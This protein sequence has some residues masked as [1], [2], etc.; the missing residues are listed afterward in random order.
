ML[1]IATG[2]SPDY[3]LKE[4]ATGRENYYTGAVAEGE[5]PG[6]WWGAGAEQL[7]LAGLV[8]A[9]DMR[10]L[11]ERFLDPRDAGFG[12]PS[13]W[14]SVP[15]LGHTGRKYL[16]EDDLYAAALEREPDAAAER[17]AELRTE[18]GKAA[19]HNVAF[20]DATFSV[21]KSVTLLHTAFEARE[22]AARQAGDEATAAAWGEFRQAVEDAIW[23]GNNAALAYL[24]DKAGYA[25]V[26]HHGGAAG[27]WV[28][29]HAFTV[30]SFFQHDSRD[31]DPQLHI[32][33]AILNRI[34]GPDGV[35]RTLD[36]RAIHRWRAGAGAVGERTTEERLAATI[37]TLV[38]TRRDGKSREVVGVSAEAMSLVSNRR[39]AVTAKAAE[40][41]EAFE[42]RYG[43]APNGV[44][45]DRLAQQATLATRAAKSHDGETRGDMLDRVAARLQSDIAGGLAGIADTAL[46]ARRDGVTPQAF[47]PQ[48]VIEIALEDVASRK[49]GWTRSDLVRAV[50]AALPDYLGVPDGG[51]VAVLLD[52]ITDHALVYAIALE[53]E[54]PGSGLL[55]DELRVANGESAYIAPGGRVYCTPD[56]VRSERILLAAT[57]ARDGAALTGA[58]AERFLRTL[59]SEGLELGVD[60][61]AAVRGILTSGARVETLVGPAGTGKSYVVGN[62]ARAWT[63]PDLRPTGGPGG[64]AGRVFGLA[65]SQRATEVLTAEGLTAS[66]IARW[67]TTQDRLA[68][69]PAE[70][71][72]VDGDEA[73]RLREGDLLV[74]DESGMTD[75]AALAAIHQRADEAGAKLLLVGDHRQLAAVGAGGGMDLLATAGSRYELT[76][77]RRFSSEWER[78]ASLRLREGDQT[79][80]RAYHQQGRLL[81]SGTREDAETS[82]ARGW[83]ADHLAGRRSL[84]LV[85][86][87]EQAA[88]LSS[89]IRAELIRL[90][91]VTEAGVRLGFDG[92]T[93]GV[94]DLVEARH[95]AHH[96]AGFEG[97]RR[98]PHNRDL[99]RITAVRDDGTLE[100]TTDTHGGGVD[101][102]HG[103]TVGARFV[104]PATYVSEHLALGYAGTTHAGQGATVDTTHTVVTPMTRANALYVGM[105]R[106][107]V[108]NTA[109]VTTRVAPEDPADGTAA[110][111]ELH[112]DPVAVLAGILDTA[113]QAIDRSA[114]AIATE[115]AEEAGSARTVVELLADAAQLA[116]TERTAASLDRLVH[117][118]TLTTEQRARIAAEDGTAALTR[119]LRRA[120]LAGLDPHAVLAEAVDRGPLTG[121]RNVSNVVYS[122]IRDQHRLD[123]LGERWTDWIPQ[124]DN[125]Q[126][127]S[128][129]D[130]LAVAADQRADDLGA[131]AAVEPPAWAFQAFGDVPTDPMARQRW[132][133]DVGR[134][135]AY[136]E[137]RGHDD[138]TD[139]LGPAPK[140]GQVEEFAAHRAAW[141]ALGRPEIDREHLELSNGQLR[142]RV[143]AYDRE[144]AAAPRYVANELAGTRQAA[145]AQRQDAAVT[146]AALD[147]T[148]DPT[149]RNRLAERAAGAEA[150]AALLEQRA[151]QLQE[152]DDARGAWL[153]HTAQTRVQAELSKAELSA[154]DAADDPDDRVTAAEWKAAHDAAL[155]EDEQYREITENDIHDQAPDDRNAFLDEQQN[156]E[157]AD[158]RRDDVREI[159]DARP[160]PVLEDAVRVP[161]AA[162]TTDYLDHAGR[163][164]DEIRYR[165]TAEDGQE[166][167]AGLARSH[168][169]QHSEFDDVADGFDERELP[170]SRW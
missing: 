78:D 54:R 123:P 146:R 14:D 162:E 168:T 43:R 26:G 31:R 46:A 27:R 21:Q 74:I 18:A 153:A 80:L 70:R 25:R 103:P 40:L 23:A 150:M 67:L 138:P 9:Q 109:H 5:P 110:R 16:S 114:V 20:L 112:R 79:V 111:H 130:R 24:E 163:I 37:G 122:R 105:S 64:G 8:D 34:Q 107:R 128:Y 149:E 39:H 164:L 148:P 69:A 131:A 124:T 161:E 140:P 132:C 121:A 166:E 84:L 15:T 19:R 22:V 101:S 58:Q 159:A 81:D 75:T 36:S 45:R 88:R 137:V 156:A 51:D 117:D 49:S 165:D 158:S 133:D 87:N 68:A 66:N 71:R 126:W 82:A 7:G 127:S 152:I 76:D 4:V 96:L 120:E 13:R 145:E 91:R 33:N 55:P 59:R 90:G 106:G 56:Q 160:A 170:D 155:S 65:T 11:Y 99:Y 48:A 62:L 118:G 47:N 44:E 95:N 53:S 157:T 1:R 6:R 3:L 2:Y 17:R 136:R 108:R 143:R 50:N 32:H 42:T 93:A 61:A 52:Q 35:W 83:L 169:E 97:N 60:Q 92:T 100:V 115:S 63:D 94:G 28:D 12:D 154:R 72:T 29:A 89:S 86:T 98:G 73:W 38:A 30:A 119:V 135:A 144:L 113:D 116:A 125:L 139:A 142:I 41:I 104:L 129:L 85:D 151:T 77:A 147:T 102:A 167:R 57:S 141:R 134:V 10:A